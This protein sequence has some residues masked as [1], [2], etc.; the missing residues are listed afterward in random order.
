MNM[1]EAK[2]EL[3]G[4]TFTIDSTQTGIT[5]SYLNLVPRIEQ[6]SQQNQRTGNDVKIVSGLIRGHISTRTRDATTNPLGGPILVKIWLCRYKTANT[7]SLLN[8]NADTAFFEGGTGG[9]IGFSGTIQ[10]MSN[11]PN[12]DSWDMLQTKEY[13]IGTASQSNSMPASTVF[14]DNSP[15]C[16]AFE[17]DLTKYLKGT[18]QYLDNTSSVSTNKNLF[19]VFQATYAFTGSTTEA[20]E[21]A[22]CTYTM[23]HQ[24][25]DA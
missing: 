7:S 3:S 23:R 21:L 20:Y 24:Y 12:V 14:F 16:I 10:D 18:T 8:T 19:L 2:Q 17:F 9:A 4:G 5:P 13:K 6:G 11:F 22:D 15:A 1:C 25:I